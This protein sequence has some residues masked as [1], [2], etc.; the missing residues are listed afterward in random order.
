VGNARLTKA[1]TSQEAWPEVAPKMTKVPLARAAV[2][3]RQSCASRMRRGRARKARLNHSLRLSAFRLRI[4]F[5]FF[6]R[7]PDE[8]KCNPGAM[9]SEA[10]LSEEPR[11]AP[12]LLFFAPH[13][14]LHVTTFAK[15]GR[16]CAARTRFHGPRMKAAH[17][18]PNRTRKTGR[19]PRARRAANESCWP[20]GCDR[21]SRCRPRKTASAPAAF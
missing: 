5:F 1:A 9:T 17:A 4:S 13:F 2:E 3:R 16:A 19:I 7:S 8:T 20:D 11:Q 18:P 6:L 14:A 15:L 21:H 12:P 10:G